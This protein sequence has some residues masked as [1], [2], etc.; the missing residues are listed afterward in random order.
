MKTFYKTNIPG[1]VGIGILFL[2]T[3]TPASYF[4]QAAAP[5]KLNLQ[6]KAVSPQVKAAI[7]FA[8]LVKRVSPSVVNIY[9]TKKVKDVPTM[10]LFFDDP[11]FRQFFGDPW[12]GQ[13]RVPPE[14]REQALGS[15]VVVSEDGYL[16]TNNHV[17]DGADE[18]KV[19]LADEKT[20][21]EAKVVG[22]DPQTD[23]AVLKVDGKKLPAI[24]INRVT[25]SSK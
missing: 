25:L 6:D 16:L 10:I 14:R 23:I 24:V 1:A 17:V 12:G 13:G 7:S 21:L 4:V 11:F 9:T 15:G 8:P 18:I 2:I 20:V 19:A 3:Q 5:L 22:A